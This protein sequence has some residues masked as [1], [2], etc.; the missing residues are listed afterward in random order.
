VIAVI[1]VM[2]GEKGAGKTKVML[3]M[4]N[5]AANVEMGKV[6]FIN[7]GN[8][9]MYDLDRLVRMVN[10]DDFHI[11]DLGVFLGFIQGIIA[12]DYDITHIFIDSLLKAV[13]ADMVETE[14]FLDG[15]LQVS[16]RYNVKFTIT[17]SGDASLATDG[18]K[19]YFIK[20]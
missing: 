12:G 5:A 1:K 20:F 18:V 9:F 8:R 14:A 4:V 16:E 10:T 3:E 11:K 2:M 19:K 15:L 7:K 13:K 6:V 17:I